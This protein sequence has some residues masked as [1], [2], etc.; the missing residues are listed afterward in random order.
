[1]IVRGCFALIAV[2]SA[3]IVAA[4]TVGYDSAAIG[5]SGNSSYVQDG[6]TSDSRS[7][8][9]RSP[10]GDLLEASVFGGAH[11]SPEPLLKKWHEL[12]ADIERDRAILERCRLDA[13]ACPPAAQRFLEV[14]HAADGKSGRALIGAVNR[15]VNL[16]IQSTSDVVQH[17]VGDRWS[18]PIETFAA[19]RGD[20]EDYAIAKYVA[21]TEIGVA[22]EDARLLMVRNIHTH[23][24]HALLAVR[25]E[26]RWLVL[27]SRHF[28]LVD[29]VDATD[30]VAFMALDV[31]RP[32]RMAEPL[33][34]TMAAI[35]ASP[36]WAKLQPL[37]VR[38]S[39]WWSD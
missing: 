39:G 37:S 15:A 19:G 18:A 27:D 24:D 2:A 30:F 28:A 21:L 1:M 17:G 35:N 32:A 14:M 5:F 36:I 12:A 4:A 22:K 33:L 11:L 7:D 26:D 13:Q 16:S 8:G 9:G 10:N 31:E 25:H 6:R 38:Y 23:T 29:A 3:T 20:C 34:L